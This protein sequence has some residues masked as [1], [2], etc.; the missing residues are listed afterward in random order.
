VTEPIT[1]YLTFI[2]SPNTTSSPVL[3]IGATNP[4]STEVNASTRMEATSS[5]AQDFTNTIRSTA[6]GSEA[7]APPADRLPGTPP[8]P[9]A[10]P[11]AE[12]SSVENALQIANEAMATISFSDT[13]GVALERIKWV[14]DIVSPIA[15][16]RY[17]VLFVNHWL[18]RM[19]SSVESVCEN[20]IWSTFCDPQGESDSFTLLSA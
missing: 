8:P 18:S 5:I 4:Q 3:P 14:M 17:D 6:I 19:S 12:M 2:V 16:V 20:G 15:E 9:A 10:D 13:W 7:L 1:L 11:R